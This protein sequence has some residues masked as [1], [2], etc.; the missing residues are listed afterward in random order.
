MGD[1]TVGVP[2]EQCSRSSRWYYHK[3][4]FKSVRVRISP[5][6]ITLSNNL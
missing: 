3:D 4:K 1:T 6:I 2:V 5:V